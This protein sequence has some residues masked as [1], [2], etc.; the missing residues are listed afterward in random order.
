MATTG[1]RRTT[2][3]AEEIQLRK[4]DVNITSFRQKMGE[5]NDLVNKYGKWQYTFGQNKGHPTLIT[6]ESRVVRE[7]DPSTGGTREIQLPSRQVTLNKEFLDS[8]WNAIQLL[9]QQAEEQFRI[10]SDRTRTK[11]PVVPNSHEAKRRDLARGLAPLIEIDP[12]FADWLLGQLRNMNGGQGIPL[13]EKN[14]RPDSKSKSKPTYVYTQNGTFPLASFK[15]LDGTLSGGRRIISSDVAFNILNIYA[16]N[17]QL[18]RLSA[19]NNILAAQGIR[20]TE[21]G[22]LIIQPAPESEIKNRG[23]AQQQVSQ[24]FAECEFNHTQ[25]GLDQT[26]SDLLTTRDPRTGAQ[27]LSAVNVVA[28]PPSEEKKAKPSRS[29]RSSARNLPTTVVPLSANNFPRNN[30]KRI[31]QYFQMNISYSEYKSRAEM[32]GVTNPQ[33]P[34]D[35]SVEDKARNTPAG[36]L[37][38]KETTLATPPLT[39]A[40][41]DIMKEEESKSR[42]SIL[43]DEKSVA[44]LYAERDA[45]KNYYEVLNQ[46]ETAG[47]E[48]RCKNYFKMFPGRKAA[49]G[50][51]RKKAAPKGAEC[52]FTY[53]VFDQPGQR[54]GA[55]G[56]YPMWSKCMKQTQQQQP[57]GGQTVQGPGIGGEQKGPAVLQAQPAFQPGQSVQSVGTFQP[58]QPAQLGSTLQAGQPLTSQSLA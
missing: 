48:E 23:T 10:A 30:L 27:N 14:V 35:L 13:L 44:A 15:G 55:T 3:S 9:S 26:L 5:L 46:R 53:I 21:G 6:I 7:P 22:P 12:R 37:I 18:Y 50:P 45:V 24:Q 42:A 47:R 11:K 16:L 39:A 25:L 31:I 20:L 1:R 28:T 33:F 40:A 58:G 36:Y 57:Q 34:Y 2:L 52:N 19:Y 51:G 38:K 32:K 56:N 17:N 43:N 4:G 29:Q 8:V 49:A 54:L 41:Y